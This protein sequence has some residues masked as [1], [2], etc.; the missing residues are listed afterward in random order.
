MTVTIWGVVADATGS[1]VQQVLGTNDYG[2]V[3]LRH[4]CYSMPASCYAR[5][6]PAHIELDI[7]HHDVVGQVRYLERDEQ[8]R[9][10]A[11]CEASDEAVRAWVTDHPASA[12]PPAAGGT[13]PKPN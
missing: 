13:T 1:V 6:Q 3:E 2:Q 5:V 9:L 12:R 11:V 4:N 7:D 10:H 8:G